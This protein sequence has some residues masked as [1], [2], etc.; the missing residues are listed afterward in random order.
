MPARAS[1]LVLDDYCKCLSNIVHPIIYATFA[2]RPHLFAMISYS[3][4]A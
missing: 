1:Y 4:Q 2:M 3:A